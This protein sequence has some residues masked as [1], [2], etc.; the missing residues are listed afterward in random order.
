M[1]A[2]F[3]V[4]TRGG[5]RTIPA[6]MPLNRK[7][8]GGLLAGIGLML[9]PL[10]W[11]NDAFVNLPLAMAFAW[12]VSSP[13]RA[14]WKSV[15]F[16]IALVLGYWLTNIIG[17][18]LLHQGARAVLEREPSG[19]PGRLKHDVLISLGY[20]ALIAS[21]IKLGVLKPIGEYFPG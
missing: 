20:T 3:R 14:E 2:M 4:A 6:L 17:L 12:L 8:G 10:T 1:T 18:I 15:V 19:A 5:M 16:Q 11:W 13:A 21:L 9:S 7:I